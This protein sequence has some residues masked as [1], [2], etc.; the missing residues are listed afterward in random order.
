MFTGL[1]L[2]VASL[3]IYIIACGFYFSTFKF[4]NEKL[5]IIGMI[6]LALAQLTGISA[7]FFIKP[8]T[9]VIWVFYL[10][11]SGMMWMSMLNRYKYLK[12]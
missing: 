10:L 11:F 1:I 6:L 4:E 9:I 7:I 8:M 5:S 12:S 2:Q 3:A